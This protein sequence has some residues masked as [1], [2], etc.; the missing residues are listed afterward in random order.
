MSYFQISWVGKHGFFHSA[1]LNAVTVAVNMGH[2]RGVIVMP[3]KGENIYRRKDG[4]WEG[5]YIKTHRSNGKAQYTSVYGKT[6]AEVKQK[7]LTARIDQLQESSKNSA[8]I[9]YKVVIQGWLSL[10]RVRVKE[11]TYSRYVHLA[12]THILPH[13][14]EL[15][16]EQLTSQ[17]V[18]QHISF[19]LSDGR[20][21]G[22][23][24]LSPKTTSDILTVIKGSI[25]YGRCSGY[26]VQCHLDMLSIKK[27][28]VDMRVLGKEEQKQLLSVLLN[29]TD[30]RKLGVLICLYTGIRIG[31]VCALKWENIDLSCGVLTIRE[32]LQRIQEPPAESGKKTKVVITAPKSK[33]SVRDIPLPSFLTKLAQPFRANP[34]AFILTGQV[35]KFIEPRLLQYSFKKYTKECGLDDVNYHALRHTFATRCIELGFDVKTLSEILG[36]TSVTITLNR[37]VHSSMDTKRTNMEKLKL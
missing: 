12:H 23:G 4:R 35:D 22:Q 33:R 25:E 30:L 37:Y 11:S 18:E 9:K 34:K 29:N 13:L 7:L 14:G 5:R 6:Y 32:T 36:H 1:A 17:L 21:D 15:P 10:A 24:G 19:L 28:V 3:K 20:L 26:T 2:L 8:S 16:F 27:P 31:E